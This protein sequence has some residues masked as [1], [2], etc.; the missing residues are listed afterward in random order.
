MNFCF[1]SAPRVSVDGPIQYSPH[2]VRYVEVF[3][4]LLDYFKAILMGTVK[5][6]SLSALSVSFHPLSRDSS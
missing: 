6:L 5:T 1:L 2:R 3:A 4:S